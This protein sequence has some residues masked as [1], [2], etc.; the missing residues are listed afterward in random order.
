MRFRDE[1][2]SAVV[3]FISDTLLA[4]ALGDEFIDGLNLKL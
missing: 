1:H 4:L 3:N 2:P